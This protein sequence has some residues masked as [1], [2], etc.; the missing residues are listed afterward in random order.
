MS[1]RAGKGRE[2][3]GK[4]AWRDAFTFLS[5]AHRAEP[6]PPADRE[7]LATAAYLVGE[8]DTGLDVWADAHQA[9]VD[10]DDPPGAARCAYWIGFCLSVR[11]EQARG[12]GWFARAM[13]VLEAWDGECAEEGYLQIPAAIRAATRGDA[14]G[15]LSAFTRAEEVGQG[16]ADRDLIT[17]G[18]HGRGR[19]LIHMGRADDGVA[20]LDEVM[21]AVTADELS[22][23]VAGDIYCSVL[24]ACEELFD[25]RRAREWTAAMTRWIEAQP[26]LVPFRGQ[27]LVRRAEVFRFCGQWEE[28][29]EEA[30]LASR[31]LTR[32][33]ARPAAGSAFYQ[34][35]ELHRLQG[36]F[37][38]A[39]EAYREASRWG[40]SP[41]P[42]LPLLR[43][44][45]GRIDHA[46]SG[47]RRALGAAR[48]PIRRAALLPALAEILLAAGEVD[49]A[50]Q[51][52]E[53]LEEL[54]RRLGA[55]PL[56]A[57]TAAAR[58]AVL[59]AEGKAEEAVPVL[60][61]ARRAWT[62]LDC[63]YRTAIVRVL[64]ARACE[65]LGDREAS[66]L[67]LAGAMEVFRELG[68][69]PQLQHVEALSR[70]AAT[71]VTAGLPAKLTPRQVQ[72]LRLVAAGRTNR[73][74][75]QE[76]FISPRTVDRHVSDIFRRLG[77]RS[78]AAA[79]AWAHRNE[80]A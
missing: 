54:A 18:R 66:E 12:N 16:F 9:Y 6:L 36:E 8:E 31:W 17:L 48:R 23:I 11:G 1:D 78:R 19:V 50:R 69:R 29:L 68:A 37:E 41:E 74:I 14:D 24:E 60:D 63:P 56:E 67:E 30:R 45:Q 38:S 52:V 49:E 15:A 13:R 43:L 4:K 22:P 33:P 62:A 10:A 25:P 51:A 26:D 20:L 61:R 65:A 70:R 76:L 64:A 32:P 55:E 35:G 2:A 75:G 3:F 46:V 47:I 58:G 72:V 77:V 79:A 71:R 34:K 27:C 59:L 42:G 57:E 39:E 5:D 21:V 53:E 7:R 28:A 40:R 73:Q 44:A 80:L